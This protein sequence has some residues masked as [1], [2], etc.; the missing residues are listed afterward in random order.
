MKIKKPSNVHLFRTK[1]FDKIDYNFIYSIFEDISSKYSA[2]NIFITYDEPVEITNNKLESITINKAEAVRTINEIIKSPHFNKLTKN[3]IEILTKKLTSKKQYK[4]SWNTIF[5]LCKSIRVSNKK[6]KKDD[7][8]IILTNTANINNYFSANDDTGKNGFVHTDQWDIFLPGYEKAYP[9]A[10]EII[11]LFVH[12]NMGCTYEEIV[13]KYAHKEPIGCI[14]D[15]CGTNK[16]DVQIKIRTGDI[17]NKCLEALKENLQ[18]ESVYHILMILNEIRDKTLWTIRY[19][20]VNEKVS[21]IKLIYKEDDIELE[22]IDYGKKFD[23]EEGGNVR[24]AIYTYLLK[25][26]DGLPTTSDR[27]TEDQLDRLTK[28]YQTVAT[29]QSRSYEYAKETMLNQFLKKGDKLNRKANLDPEI[30]R[31]KSKLNTYLQRSV[32]GDVP[33]EQYKID[34]IKNKVTGNIYKVALDKSMI[35]EI[36]I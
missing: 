2:K 30:Y 25:Y 17:C 31:V 1:D 28:I 15:M 22:F 5:E 18:F 7:H 3:E 13:K 29:G 23:F 8:V 6:I 12:A 21:R 26:E 19:R 16:T 14:S 27:L 32:I 11:G 36:S 35:K 9:I 20:K 4:T 33:F 34:L 10:Y 24:K